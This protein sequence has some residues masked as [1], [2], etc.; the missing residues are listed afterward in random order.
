MFCDFLRTHCSKCV[1]AV[2]VVLVIFQYHFSALYEE[3]GRLNGSHFT[4]KLADMLRLS[5]AAVTH[6]DTDSNH[7]AS[8]NINMTLI[9]L[10]KSSNSSDP[11]AH[12]LVVD[13]LNFTRKTSTCP[14]VSPLLGE[15]HLTRFLIHNII[16]DGF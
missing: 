13:A 8:A 7:L 14:I 12:D 5:A 3:I 6:N 2:L 11:F 9:T 10:H 15:S 4:F 1:I 16:R